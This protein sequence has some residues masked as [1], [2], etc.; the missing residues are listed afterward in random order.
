MES[1][2]RHLI[3][4]HVVENLD[5]LASVL[6]AF[7]QQVIVGVGIDAALQQ[8]AAPNDMA[9]AGVDG[10]AELVVGCDDDAAAAADVEVENLMASS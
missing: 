9:V 1:V 6:V 3:G 5:A 8:V 10:V 4:A 7:E 2:A